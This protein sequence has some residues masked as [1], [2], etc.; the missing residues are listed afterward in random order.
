MKMSVSVA[1]SNLAKLMAQENLLVES[2]NVETAYFDL[3]S[4]TVVLP[5]LKKDISPDVQDLFISHEISHALHTPTDEWNEIIESKTVKK[6]IVNVVEDARIETAI[7]RKYP[8][9]KAIYSRAY[10]TLME[11]DFFG[12][13][14]IGIDT[15]NF[16][17]RLNLY[18]K[19]GFI[20]GIDFSEKEQVFVSRAE[21]TKTFADVV[22]LSKDIEEFIKQEYEENVEDYKQSLNFDEIG[23]EDDSGFEKFGQ[24]K[25]EKTEN[26]ESDLSEFGDF[27]DSL[28]NDGGMLE[29]LDSLDDLLESF[30]DNYSKEEIKN[31]YANDSKVNL[32]VNVP[33]FDVD[34]FIVSPQTLISRITE[35]CPQILLKSEDEFQEFKSQN[36]DVVSYLAKEFNLKKNAAARKKLKISKTGDL[37]NNKLYSYKFNDDIFKRSIKTN[38][39]KNHSMIFYLDWS[40][41]M[42][43]LI[44]DTIKQLLCLV[45]FCKKVNIPYEVYAFSS[46]YDEYSQHSNVENE[47][48]I[49]P[50]RLFNLFSYK[51]TN[52]EFITMANIL[53]KYDSY[54]FKS[55]HELAVYYQNRLNYLPRWFVLGSTPLNHA[56]ILSDKI[57]KRFKSIT[58][59]DIVSNIF[60]TDGE[61]HGMHFYKDQY[62]KRIS[63]RAY[64]VFLRNMETKVTQKINISDKMSE[65]NSILDFIKQTNDTRFFGFRLA[66]IGDLKYSCFEF[67]GDYNHSDRWKEMKSNGC[68]K[69]KKSSFDEFFFVRPNLIKEDID[70]D[71]IGENA[72]VNTI[73]KKFSKSMSGK[74]NNRIFLR[75]FIDFI[76]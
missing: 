53:L 1:K 70:F 66:S 59:T 60:L 18:T 49:E 67:F 7:K 42:A 35:H 38:G 62:H 6:S 9:L 24:D 48:E 34:K 37:N 26:S 36:L 33:D 58:R 63:N 54:G 22:Q 65:T 28:D 11:V 5:E 57:S 3:N 8:G 47:L 23:F 13:S 45:L 52:K 16:I 30:T 69:A 17:D 72:S 43:S 73:F 19:V 21:K 14:R 68:L 44:E 4:R 39:E 31:F 2:R 75:K 29:D 51:M 12:L 20:P 40:G 32:Y 64:N 41:S 56:L 61:S 25:A 71:N 15:L 55:K 50:L 46:E 27:S 10:N 74:Q 76:S